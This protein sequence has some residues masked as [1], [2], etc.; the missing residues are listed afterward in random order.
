M[1]DVKFCEICFV[2]TITVCSIQ[3]AKTVKFLSK[4]SQ[5][6]YFCIMVPGWVVGID[7]HMSAVTQELFTLRTDSV[8]VPQLDTLDWFDELRVVHLCLKPLCKQTSNTVTKTESEN[9]R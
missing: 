3:Y 9:S 5:V 2:S 6:A 1:S 7:E 4:L 8:N